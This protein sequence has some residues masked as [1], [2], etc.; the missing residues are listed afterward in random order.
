[1]SIK[2]VTIIVAA[3]AA[4]SVSIAKA[5][6]YTAINNAWA[7]Q[8]NAQMDAVRNGITAS[9]LNNPELMALNRAGVCGYGL[10]PQQFAEKWAATGGCTPEG[11]RRY[12]DTT[13]D[14]ANRDRRAYD[15]YRAA[16]DER[17]RAQGDFMAGGDDIATQRGLMNGGYNWYQN[18]PMGP[19]WYR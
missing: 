2:F 8:Q 4:G 13:A 10:T 16:E 11:Y 15:D 18:G 9:N 1:M 19:G 12:N 3:V 6:D 14:I 17:A 5:Q 7:A